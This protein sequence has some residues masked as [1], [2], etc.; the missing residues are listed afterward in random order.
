MTELVAIVGSRG[1]KDM[2]AVCAEVRRLPAGTV[3]V[4]GGARGVDQ[5]AVSEADAVGLV[6]V[7][8]HPPWNVKGPSAGPI[9]NSVI[10]RIADRC[11]AF[12]DGQSP[13]TRDTIDKFT[14]AGKPVSVI[15][16]KRSKS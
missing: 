10:V 5:M 14:K 11:I 13:G 15:K 7:V 4:S 2:E 9:R 1:W 16:P 12:W 6:T 8:V 3:V